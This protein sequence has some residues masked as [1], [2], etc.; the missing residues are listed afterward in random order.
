MGRDICR[1][2]GSRAVRPAPV[3]LQSS[4]EES[5]GGRA[6]SEFFACAVCGDNWLVLSEELDGGEG[7]RTVIHQVEREPLLRKVA[8][9]AGAVGASNGGS[10]EYLVGEDVVDPAI[11]RD[12]LLDRRL[13]LRQEAL[14]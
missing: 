1:A 9:T 14:N 8:H 7:A 10:Y 13:R 11:W 4:G 12:L 5:I 3:L 2:C 6:E